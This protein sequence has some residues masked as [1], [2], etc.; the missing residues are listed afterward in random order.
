MFEILSQHILHLNRTYGKM[1]TVQY[2]VIVL[3]PEENEEKKREMDF[4][5]LLFFAQSESQA[6]PCDRQMKYNSTS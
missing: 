4:E 6:L 3:Y 2:T 5:I 1:N